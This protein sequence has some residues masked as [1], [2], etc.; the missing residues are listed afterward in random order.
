MKISTKLKKTIN[1]AVVRINSE[2]I[3]INWQIPYL[4]KNPT[5]GSGTGFF[6]DKNYILTCAHVISHAKNIYIEIPGFTNEKYSC[7]IVGICPEFDIG[8]LKILNYDSKYFLELG[9]SE[10]LKS[11]MDVFVVGYPRSYT[12]NSNNPINN[13]KY[14]I[15]VISGQQY[16]LIQTDS[17][18]NPG[19]S[20]G[21]L[22]YE[23]KVIGINSLKLVADNVENVAYAIPINY[24]KVIKNDFSD[25][26]I[27]RPSLGFEY[28]NT[29]ENIIE[30]LTNH[31][32]KK[33]IIISKIF[34]DSILKHSKIKEGAI[35]TKI[36]NVEINNYGLINKIWIGTKLSIDNIL[37]LF[38]KDDKIKIS[39]Y[40]SDKKKIKN[41][42]N[43]T[44]K[45][46]TIQLKPHK[47]KIRELFP[48]F[49]PIQY[50]VLSGVIFMN[51]TLNNINDNNYEKLFQYTHKSEK[52]KPVV[53]VS[54][55]F[56]NTKV[57]I[58][59]NIKANDVITKINDI[60]ISSISNF[61]KILEKP[62]MLNEKKFLK[63]ENNNQ[64]YMLI[65]YESIVEEDNIFSEIYKYEKYNLMV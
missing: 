56:P 20:G 45:I 11:G 30:E 52:D 33:G 27:H 44:E 13:L 54:F 59:N 16:G 25:K 64:K 19:N 48:V 61:Q 57:N 4:L 22:F 42:N 40:S 24:Y 43:S 1:N 18:I 9:N 2:S 8:L 10:I 31:K 55:I 37:N 28:N 6:I 38:K 36:N 7:E 26:I 3:N 49:E 34:S 17:A 47:Y 15:G 29:D 46:I 41:K 14:T 39:Y 53:I 21:P 51:L 58:V 63:I 65:S 5:K 23:N 12:S 62:I 35:I 60:E 32:I 50:F